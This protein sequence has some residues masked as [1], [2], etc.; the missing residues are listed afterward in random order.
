MFDLLYKDKEGRALNPFLPP[1]PPPRKLS[2]QHF[3][4]A[5]LLDE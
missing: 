3:I 5:V 1:P 4:L 2:V